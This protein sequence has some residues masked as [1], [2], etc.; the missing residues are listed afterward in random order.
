MNEAFMM[1]ASE[2]TVVTLLAG[3]VSAL[4]AVVGY[5]W[6]MLVKSVDEIKGKLND[7]EQ[8]REDLWKALMQHNHT[9]GE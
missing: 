8:D 3:A 4:T 9:E 1:G 6:R 2:P 5:L 7:C